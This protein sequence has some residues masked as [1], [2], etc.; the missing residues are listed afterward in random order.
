MIKLPVLLFNTSY[1]RYL[2]GII[3]LALIVVQPVAANE[4]AS[5]KQPEALNKRIKSLEKSLNQVKG[6]RTEAAKKVKQSEKL[7]AQTARG[8]RDNINSSKKLQKQLN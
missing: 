4:K 7:I 2:L 8:I 5:E 1:I 6:D 3:C